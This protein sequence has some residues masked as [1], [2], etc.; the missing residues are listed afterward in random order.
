MTLDLGPVQLRDVTAANFDA[1][2]ALEVTAEQR[3][4]LD[5]NVES[6]AWAYVAPECQ[7]F[8]IYAGETPVGLAS[9]G[10]V[11]ADGRCWIIH[12]M[13]DAHYQHGGIGRAALE[14]LLGR[15]AE[16]SGGAR[17]AVAV[18]PENAAAL[19]LYETFGFH[20]TGQRQNGEVIL[21]RDATA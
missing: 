4:F 19:R 12:L 3:D 8:A 9:Y 11:P 6:I 21:W 7:P 5:S 20:D 14:Q 17:I 1:L 13:I 15:M 10:Y 16:V 2:I 18:N